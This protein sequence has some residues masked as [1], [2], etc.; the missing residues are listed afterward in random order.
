MA[1]IRY[2]EACQLRQLLNALEDKDGLEFPVCVEHRDQPDFVLTTR[3]STI[4]LEVTSFTDEEVRRADHLVVT[5]FPNAFIPN[6]F[7]TN[8]AFQEIRRSPSNEEIIDT[9]FNWETPGEDVIETAEH[10]WQRI[11]ASVQIKQQKFHS[12]TFDK[13]DEN[14]LMLSD[15]PNPFSDRITDD[16]LSRHLGSASKQR[17]VFGPEFDRIYIL[18]GR[19]RFTLRKTTNLSESQV[20]LPSS[21]IRKRRR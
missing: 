10:L 11:V 4:G 3:A 8:K 14:W 12:A 5:H 15:Y 20:T 6:A 7:T 21:T 13:F 16:I 17:H 19:R 1:K 9:M 2:L 18:Y